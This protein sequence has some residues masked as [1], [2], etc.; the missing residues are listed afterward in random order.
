MFNTQYAKFIEALLIKTKAGDLEWE[1]L[2]HN[3]RLCIQ[4]GWTDAL[5]PPEFDVEDSYCTKLDNYY[6]VLFSPTG[7]PINLYVIP[8]TFR[9]IVRLDAS[10]YGEYITRLMNEVR[11]TF[12]D[13]DSFIESVVNRADAEQHN[14]HK[15][16]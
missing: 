12:P 7:E 8:Y 13:A 5:R 11:R 3:H 2:D 15:P 6:I 10:D 4:M 1:Y 9:K 14:K 16:I